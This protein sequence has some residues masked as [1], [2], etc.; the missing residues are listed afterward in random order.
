MS[1]IMGSTKFC[2]RERTWE[3]CGGS[4]NTSWDLLHHPGISD[5]HRSSAQ[6]SEFKMLKV[7]RVFKEHEKFKK[8]ET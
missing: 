4:I 7:P 2:C 3:T 1:P 5:F 6:H 8:N